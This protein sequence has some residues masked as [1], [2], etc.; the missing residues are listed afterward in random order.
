[1]RPPAVPH[2][3]LYAEAK[4]ALTRGDMT[5]AHAMFQQCPDEYRNTAQ[6][7]A[8]CTTYD[9]LLQRGLVH[10][11]ETRALREWLG[12]AAE[13]LHRAGHTAASVQEM[14]LHSGAGVLALVAADAG[15]YAAVGRYFE[16]NSSAL[17]R[18]AN[19]VDGIVAR[20]GGWQRIL[21]KC[22]PAA[23]DA[24]AP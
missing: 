18:A 21:V 1:M 23:A 10:R 2:A 15:L 11:S 24:A 22:L 20:C 5:L 9:A 7:L 8:Q 12:V 16:A 4:L 17:A 3:H 6:Y 14:A 13:R 19:G